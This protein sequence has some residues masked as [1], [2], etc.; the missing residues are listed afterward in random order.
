MN[1]NHFVEAWMMP[2]SDLREQISS[3]LDEW[4]SDIVEY[5]VARDWGCAK[6]PFGPYDIAE[7]IIELLPKVPELQWHGDQLF[8]GGLR[9]GLVEDRNGQMLL[10]AG[11]KTIGRAMPMHVARAAVEAAVR[12]VL[13]WE[14]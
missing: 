9:V 10:C 6:T 13:G 11:E 12:K 8:L 4:R 3:M 7:S 1:D 14:A 2:E 5:T